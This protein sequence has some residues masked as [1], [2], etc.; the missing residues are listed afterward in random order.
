MNVRKYIYAVGL[1]MIALISCKKDDDEDDPIVIPPRDRAEQQV[2]DDAKLVDY[3]KTHFYIDVEV[4]TDSDPDI[5]YVTRRFDTIAGDNENE[6][7]IMDSGKLVTKEIVRDGVSYKLYVLKID[8]GENAVRKPTVVDSTLVTYRGE[9]LYD[10]KDGDGDGIPDEADADTDDE[11]GTDTGKVD[12]D[13]DGIIDEA[14]ADT[15]GVEGTDAGKVDSD[16]DGIIDAK[17]PVN[18]NDPDRRV[19]DSAITPI[20][21]DMIGVVEGFKTAIIDYKGATSFTENSLDGT[22]SYSNDFGNYTVFMPSGLGYFNSPPNQ[23]IPRYSCLIFNTQLYTVNQTDHDGDGIPTYLE[24]LDGDGFVIDAD[25][26]TDGDT[27]V[28]YLD[29]DDDNDGTLTKDE[30]TVV[31]ANGDNV[32]TIDEITFYDDDDDG[33]K[34]HLDSDDRDNKNQ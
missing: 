21:L 26:N 7:S 11:K 27:A 17:D 19:F 13:N 9:L 14:D 8:E 31:D 24:D 5:E 3:L 18:N 2:V 20:W 32:I 23:D 30:I 28:N 33:I 1:T 34:N 10:N 16:N 29:V 12:S 25:D 22:V 4:N 6:V 15:D